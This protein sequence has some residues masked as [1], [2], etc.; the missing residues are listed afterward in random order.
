M[1]NK[2]NQPKK[3]LKEILLKTTANKDWWEENPTAKLAFESAMEQV[4]NLSED[5]SPRSKEKKEALM[6]FMNNL[7]DEMGNPYI[8]VFEGS[9]RASF[10]PSRMGNPLR[11]LLPYEPDTLNVYNH[12]DVENRSEDPDMQGFL[13]KQLEEA[14]LHQGSKRLRYGEQNLLSNILSEYPHAEQWQELNTLSN[15]DSRKFH[16]ARILDNL[17][18][19]EIPKT[20]SKDKRE[21]IYDKE[22]TF[23]HDAHSIR[24]PKIRQNYMKVLEDLIVKRFPKRFQ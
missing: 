16:G 3:S 9:G 5:D 15:S 18:Y 21:K 4:F 14:Y 24:E 19:R 10:K 6:E 22:G 11:S 2:Y 23:E 8:N 12:S 17:I 20:F 1:S 13:K 7:Q